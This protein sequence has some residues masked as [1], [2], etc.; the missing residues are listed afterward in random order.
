MKNNDFIILYVLV[1]GILIGGVIFGAFFS[2][3]KTYTNNPAS[4]ES[5][6]DSRFKSFEYHGH[7][8]L[9]YMDSV[10]Y[11]CTTLHDPDCPCITNNLMRLY[12]AISTK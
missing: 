8:Y 9:K 2:K 6:Y 11:Y 7:R 5:M 4:T 12:Q 1:C 3:S 10:H